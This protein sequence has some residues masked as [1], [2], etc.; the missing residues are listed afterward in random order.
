M[1]F[2]LQLLESSKEI[3]DKILEAMLPE[4]KKIINNGIKYI[5]TLQ[6]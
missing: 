6:K 2:S 1:R 3:Q 5:L 4:I